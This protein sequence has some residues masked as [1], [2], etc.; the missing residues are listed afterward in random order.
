[1]S[2]S[3][4][5]I[6]AERYQLERPLR[7][8]GMGAVWLAHHVALRIPCAVKFIHA[9]TDAPEARARFEREAIAAAQLRSPH[10]VQILD[11]G[12][13]HGMP[14]IAME[15]LEGEDLRTRLHRVGRLP[16]A[17]VH[18]IITQ[19]ARALAKAHGN[20]LVHRD[21]K[22]A[23]VF[24]VPDDD[25]EIAKVLDF[26]VAKTTAPPGAASMSTD[27]ET[28]TGAI[29]GTPFYMS[30]E[31]ARGNKSV[32]HRALRHGGG[33]SVAALHERRQHRRDGGAATTPRVSVSVCAR[34]AARLRL[35]GLELCVARDD[36]A[37]LGG[38]L[39]RSRARPRLLIRTMRHRRFSTL[40]VLSLLA[41]PISAAEKAK[42]RD[43][44][45]AGY[46]A[47]DKRD[48]VTAANRF[49]QADGIIHVATVRL[50]LARAQA[51]LGHLVDAET[52]YKKILAEGAPRRRRP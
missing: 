28:K 10:V 24:L 6:V 20:G 50:G 51:G 45:N 22:P 39:E 19:I 26:G 30:P 15:L 14:Y 1:M 8:G 37:A 44:A 43:L 7:Q 23:N 25:R 17:E 49:T 16:P 48:Y 18:A 36:G 9:T 12:V 40:S 47:L 33:V 3:A 34:A 42:A 29:L 38:T 35:G 2:P 52:T 31:Q 21:L 41:Q 27:G 32:D 13:W 5:S 4:G 46:D 11:H